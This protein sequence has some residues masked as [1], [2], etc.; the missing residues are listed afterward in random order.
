MGK[1]ATL[2]RPGWGNKWTNLYYIHPCMG[3]NYWCLSLLL[4]LGAKSCSQCQI[5]GTLC[6]LFTSCCTCHNNT[7]LRKTLFRAS[8]SIEWQHFKPIDLKIVVWINFIGTS[9]SSKDI[10]WI[11]RQRLRSINFFQSSMKGSWCWSIE[12]V[13]YI[14]IWFDQEDQVIATYLFDC[15]NEINPEQNQN[16]QLPWGNTGTPQNWQRNRSRK[17]RTQYVKMAR[18]SNILDEN[19]DKTV[20]FVSKTKK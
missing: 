2:V 19:V 5:I 3:Q 4:L 8:R 13:K 14:S 11:S 6:I 12:I 10:N 1:K 17:E 15:I 18:H 9:K 20:K 7:K 16:Y